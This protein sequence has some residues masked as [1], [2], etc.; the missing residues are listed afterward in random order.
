MPWSN[1]LEVVMLVCFAAAWPASIHKSLVSRT[2]K[3]KSLTFMII[4]LTGYIA[5]IAKVLVSHTAIYMLI[6]YTLNTTLVLCDVALYYRN[7]RIDN[8]LRVPF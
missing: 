1:I 2:R 7:Y 4:I 6:P 5:G 8:G 3:G